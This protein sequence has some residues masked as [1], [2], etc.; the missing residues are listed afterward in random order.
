MPHAVPGLVEL[1]AVGA[2]WRVLEKDFSLHLM[3]VCIEPAGVTERSI[4]GER[5]SFQGL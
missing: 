1:M 5:S 4:V 3:K 2:I